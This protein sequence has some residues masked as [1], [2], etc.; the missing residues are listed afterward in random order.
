MKKYLIFDVGGS[1]IK[2]A[3]MDTT[4]IHMKGKVKTPKDSFE[5]F[6]HAL[7]Q[8]YETFSGTIEGVALSMPGL[9][10][11]DTGYA[12]HGGSLSYIRNINIAEKIHERL[13]IPI[14]I[15]K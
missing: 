4:S 8:I 15:E 9:T 6:L 12:V 2:F 5:N 3:L 10:H 11:A 13:Q 1:F 7:E 14:Q